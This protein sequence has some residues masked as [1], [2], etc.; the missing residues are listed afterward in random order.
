MDLLIII[1]TFLIGV[2]SAFIGSIVGGGGLISIPFLMFLGLPPQ[3]AIGTN[4]FSALGL[5]VSAFIK[6]WKEKKI[7]W[8]YILPFSIIGIIAAFVGANTLLAI[9]EELLKIMVG[10]V[11][12]MMVPIIYKNKNMGIKR[13]LASSGEKLLGYFLY[14][15]AMFWFAFFGGGGGIFSRYVQIRFFGMSLIQSSGTNKLPGSI[16]SIIAIFTFANAGII[17]YSYGI[18]LFL[19]M[20]VGGYLGAGTAVKKG[21]TWVKSLFLIVI[22]VSAVKLLFF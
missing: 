13:K 16:L 9:D 21:N 15:L 11:L 17:D 4:K 1:I 18:V 10:I 20:L 7:V 3:I 2:A 12:L 8:K 14:F 5:Q 19:G 6:Y 22:L